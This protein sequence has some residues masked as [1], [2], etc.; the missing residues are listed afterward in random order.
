MVAASWRSATSP[1]ELSHHRRIWGR[2]DWD[3][4][5]SETSS[6]DYLKSPLLCL[7]KVNLDPRT[8]NGGDKHTKLSI[9]GDDD[10]LSK[11][12]ELL[13]PLDFPA[14]PV[15]AFARCDRR[16]VRRLAE[17]FGELVD[18][19]LQRPHFF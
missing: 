10:L 7:D 9:L 18:L 11:T 17:P 15:F 8:R 16:R 12:F 13:K 6:T 2:L 1:P 19:Q 3:I 5:K 4:S 14:K